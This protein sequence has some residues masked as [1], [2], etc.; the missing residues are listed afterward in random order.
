MFSLRRRHFLIGV[1]VL[2]T[3]LTNAFVAYWNIARLMRNERLVSQTFQTEA[4]IERVN[5][6]VKDL[7]SGE[8]G[9]L[10]TGDQN[11]LEAFARAQTQLAPALLDLQKIGADPQQKQTLP[12]L[13]KAVASRIAWAQR[14]IEARKRQN[15]EA[16]VALMRSANQ[17]R[18]MEDIRALSDKMREREDEL[19][20]LR[21]GEST[22]SAQDAIRTFWIGTGANVLFLGLISVLLLQAARQ[23]RQLE[24]TVLELKRAEGLRDSLSQMLVHDLRTPLTTLLV[25]LQMLGSETLG[26]LDETQKEVVHM[27][28]QSGARLLEMVNG[29]LDISKLEAGELKI[30]RG[31]FNVR[32]TLQSASGQ[33]KRDGDTSTARI[34]IEANNSLQ[35]FADHD[36]IERVVIN[37]LGNAL[38]FTPSDGHIQLRAT[39]VENLVRIEVKDSGEGIP[40]EDLHRIFDK[41]GQVESRKSG[42]KHST[43]LGLTFCKLAVEAH[44]GR[45]GVSS[46]VGQGSVFW[47]EIAS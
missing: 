8:R 34:E 4:Q 18:E 28:A 35:L 38:K 1:L 10:L 19:L 5:S 47:F 41:F 22:E 24:R 21:T 44:G 7:E 2:L 29:L 3:L 46:E 45:I 40:E 33:A 17:A 27:S 23:N 43:G 15:I 13:R 14:A 36:L 32:E 37:L 39:Q 6:L 26:P 20:S 30:S 31:N 12:L 9:F 16:A 11:H 42:L 25:P